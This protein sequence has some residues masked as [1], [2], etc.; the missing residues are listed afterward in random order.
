VSVPAGDSLVVYCDGTNVVQLSAAVEAI[1]DSIG[2]LSTNGLI[3]RTGAGTVAARTVTAGTGI[4]VTNGD[5]VSGNPTVANP[6]VTSI[7]A[8]S[9]VSINQATGA[10]TITAAGTETSSWGAGSESLP[11]WAVTGDTNT[12]LYSPGADQFGITTG[13]TSRLTIGSTGKTTV[14]ASTVSAASLNIPHGTAPTSPAN[15]DFWTTTSGIFSRINSATKTVAFTDSNITGTA[16]GITGTLAVSSG[17]TGTTTLSG[18]LKGNGVSAVSAAVSGT[19][20]LAPALANTAVS[21]AK[22]LTFNGEYDNGNSSTAA[23]VTLTNGQKQKITLTG[24]CT[25]TISATGANTGTYQLR[26]IQDATGSRTV[27]W[28]GLTSTKWLGSTSAPSI[29][30][31]ANKETIVNIFVASSTV[32]CQSMARVGAA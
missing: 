11:G 29:G 19:D 21:G 20:Y 3:A 6:G 10:V 26:L 5:G 14:Q 1:V 2:S 4:S 16:A 30:S 7:V 32:V 9:G 13:G 17:G 15:G 18:I 31:A 8:G 22:T 23:T 24:N 25:L 28:S 27:T 12:G